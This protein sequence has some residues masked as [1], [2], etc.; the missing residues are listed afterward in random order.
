MAPI[1]NVSEYERLK[2][3]GELPSPKGVALAIIRKTREE[4]LSLA[5]LGAVIKTD[6]AFVARLIKAANGLVCGVRRPAASVQDALMV[7][8]LPAVRTM[9]LGFS[10]IS[11]YRS[12][13]CDGFDY[14]HFW[15]HSLL[16]GL[17][18]Q[19]ITLRTRAAPADEVFCLGLL[20]SVGE[21][22]LATL[23][24]DDYGQVIKEQQS[25]VDIPLADLEARRFALNHSEL[26]AA[27]LADWQFPVVFCEAAGGFETLE[28]NELALGSRELTLA[29]TLMLSAQTARI[30]LAHPADRAHLMQ[31]LLRLGNH[32][33][34]DEE[35]LLA[36][37]DQV[38]VEWR[39]WGAL[40][41]VGF[42]EVPPFGELAR[43][44]TEL[45]PCDGSSSVPS[46]NAAAPEL[47]GASGLRVVVA[48]DDPATRSLLRGVLE[49]AGHQVFEA[50]DGRKGLELALE[51]QPQMMIIDWVLPQMD[52]LELTRSLRQ[53]RIGRGI[54]VLML[55]SQDD[56]ERLIE[57]FE[58]GADD[59]VNKPLRPRVLA[60]RLRAGQRV[61]RL[62]QAIQKDQEEI[63]H[64]AAELAV[65]N[66]RLQQVALTDPLTGFPNRRYAVDRMQQEWASSTRT[67]RP[68]CCM[69]IDIDQFKAV[70][71][72]YGHDVGDQVLSQGATAI[73]RSL[74]AQDVISRTGGDEF[75]VICPDTTMEA[76]LVCAERI[77]RSV[78][79]MSI[80][81][82]DQVLR[83]TISVGV[84][85]RD[86]TM[87]DPDV[88][89]KRADESAYVAKAQGRNRVAALQI[90]DASISQLASVAGER[91]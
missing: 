34:L 18:A 45:A 72:T 6:P 33:D 85:V 23:Y 27:M 86:R 77:R 44:A 26:T 37:C 52:G 25:L 56:D 76:A 61:I 9:A 16:M 67:W 1:V 84:A 69:V 20:A 54:Y 10:L 8:G 89:I 46:T 17:A 83:V 68:M 88:L 32:L 11:N 73:K 21:L 38:V 90:A 36:L 55:T 47:P 28:R 24:P 91:G 78:E 63:R 19:A 66:R 80:N 71:D 30:C 82:G 64:F 13:R 15:S 87:S 40:L 4:N 50:V 29:R 49:R 22:A 62:Q 60:A 65:T 79:I 70:N 31:A 51:I 43:V 57:A 81:V 12:G 75:L 3:T 39:V 5:D 58:N 59:F 14:E 2:A 53:T 7:V 42:S 74:R 48:D 41:S 35:A